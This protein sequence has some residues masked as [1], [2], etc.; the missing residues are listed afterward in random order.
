MRPQAS[1]LLKSLACLAI[2]VTAGCAHSVHQL[3]T[4]DFQPG[5]AI[6]SG[7]MVKSQTEQFVVLFFV[8][9]T[10]YVDQAYQQL[11]NTCPDGMVTGITTEYSTS[12]GFFSW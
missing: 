8:G 3:H 12:L 11:M 4:S 10:D 6:E 5:T 1:L 2:A 9:Q 7:Q